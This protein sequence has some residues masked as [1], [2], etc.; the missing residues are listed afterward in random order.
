MVDRYMNRNTTTQMVH[1]YMRI[2][3]SAVMDRWIDSNLTVMHPTNDFIFQ[4]GKRV[5]FGKVAMKCKGMYKKTFK[6]NQNVYILV[7]GF[8]VFTFTAL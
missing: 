4:C 2:L 1:T 7:D 6:N 3:R 5:K 8:H